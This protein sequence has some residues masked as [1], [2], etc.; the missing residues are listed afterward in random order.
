MNKKFE[1][2]FLGLT[3]ADIVAFVFL[4]LLVITSASISK[5]IL[6]FLYQKVFL[7]ESLFWG[8]SLLFIF[9]TICVSLLYAL[10]KNFV[11]PN[12]DINL[13]S[14]FAIFMILFVFYVGTEFLYG[15]YPSYLPYNLVTENEFEIECSYNI[16]KYRAKYDVLIEN[17]PLFCYLNHNNPHFLRFNDDVKIIYQNR[18]DAEMHNL[19]SVNDD[20]NPYFLITNITKVDTFIDLYISWYNT[21]KNITTEYFFIPTTKQVYSIAEF[22]IREVRKLTYFITL[23]SIAVFSVLSGVNNFKSINK[24][25]E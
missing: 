6:F 23:I 7:G 10:L 21:S 9:I 12:R 25:S 17:R 8:V 20:G 1:I 11:F 14:V 3:F 2:L 13:Y 24:K 16:N 15:L 18:D 19:M 4:L 22:D 5:D